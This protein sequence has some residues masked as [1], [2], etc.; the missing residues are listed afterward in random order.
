M[1]EGCLSKIKNFPQQWKTAI[2]NND[3]QFGWYSK[4][5]KPLST[6]SY[7]S[8]TQYYEACENMQD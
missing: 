3:P 4:T 7:L 5:Q 1:E 6:Q 2:Q 8:V